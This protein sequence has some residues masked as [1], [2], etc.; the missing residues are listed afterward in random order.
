[1]AVGSDEERAHQSLRLHV[2]EV[3][4]TTVRANHS[5]SPSHAH[6]SSNLS[7]HLVSLNTLCAQI[8]EKNLPVIPAHHQRLVRVHGEGLLHAEV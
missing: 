2:E 3:H 5:C 7:R 6:A 1:M 4:P 8:D